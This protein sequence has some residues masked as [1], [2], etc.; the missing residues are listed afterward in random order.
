MWVVPEKG[1]SEGGIFAGPVAYDIG[2]GPFELEDWTERGLGAYSGGL[3]YKASFTLRA[4]PEGRLALDLGRVRGTAEAWVN[5]RGT[6]GRIWS[7]YRF[8]ITAAAQ[9][10]LNHV[11]VLICN[12][13]GP[14]LNAVSPTHFISTS[15]TVSGLFGPVVVCQR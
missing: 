7:P 15:Q 10:G 5:G 8:D 11:E 13:L 14:Y 2:Q 4:A 6:G 12:T 1:R 3:R 9:E